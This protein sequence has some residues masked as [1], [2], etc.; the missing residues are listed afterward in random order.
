VTR[1]PIALAAASVA[2]L[3]PSSAHA[4]SGVANGVHVRTVSDGVVVYFGI[5][6][7]QAFAQV[8]GRQLRV[9]C[10]A[11]SDPQLLTPTEES[12][13]SE[14]PISRRLRL[15]HVGG[16]GGQPAWDVCEVGRAG[17][18]PV[19]TVGLT[20]NGRAHVDEQR[21]TRKLL[22]AFTFGSDRSH[23]GFAMPATAEIV[24]LSHGALV[25]L[26]DAAA[27]PPAGRIGYF[28]DGARHAAVAVLSAAGR[29]LFLELDGDAFKSNVLGYLDSI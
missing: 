23:D 27:S 10:V 28:S 22:Y 16:A 26:P 21:L 4:G 20:A 17:N 3:V 8:R 12:F 11:Y 29:R 13:T 7:A 6:A 1:L 24:Q 25:A 2:L 18:A 9:R 15:I 14:Q 5:H 19:A